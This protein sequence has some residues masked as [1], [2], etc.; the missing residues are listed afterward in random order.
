MGGNKYN[1]YVV[2][3]E[4][5]TGT[6]KIKDFDIQVGKTSADSAN[7]KIYTNAGATIEIAGGGNS[8]ITLKVISDNDDDTYEGPT[9]PANPSHLEFTIFQ[10]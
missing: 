10:S 8:Q 9:L 5:F 1:V 4:Q 2:N 3:V 7:Q 6:S